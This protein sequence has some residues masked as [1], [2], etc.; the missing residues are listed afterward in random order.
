MR[1]PRMI[2]VGALALAAAVAALALGPTAWAGFGPL[3]LAGATLT[4]LE[5]LWVV[6]RDFP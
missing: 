6:R 2:R 4:L 5:R 3:L 1:H